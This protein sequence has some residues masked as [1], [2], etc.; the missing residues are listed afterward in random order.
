RRRRQ[1]LRQGHPADERDALLGDRRHRLL[2]LAV[3]RAHALTVADLRGHA[4]PRAHGL[5][6][7][8]VRDPPSSARVGGARLHQHPALDLDA[9]RR[10]FCGAGRA[11]SAGRGRPRVL[12]TPQMTMGGALGAITLIGAVVMTAAAQEKTKVT[13]GTATPGGG[14]PVYGQP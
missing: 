2:V 12:S 13:L 11:G 14:F 7:V 6:I 8:P 1:A 3:L 4:H 9:G 5:R 10:T